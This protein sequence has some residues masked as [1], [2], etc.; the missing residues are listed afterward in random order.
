MRCLLF[1]HY[2]ECLIA[3]QC[4]DSTRSHAD[5]E[6]NFRYFSI[7][8]LSQGMV[9]QM[10]K[11]SFL[12]IFATLLISITACSNKSKEEQL[13]EGL[14]L[15][16][17]GNI[18]GAMVIYKSL[19][20]DA[21][22]YF[23]VRYELGN[24]YLESGLFEKAEKEFLKVA[25]QNPGFKEVNR[26]LSRVYVATERF[27]EA[28][29]E[30]GK[31]LEAVPTDAEAAS[32]R[33]II[34]AK[35]ENDMEAEK[36]FKA[37]LGIDPQL[38]SAKM[39]LAHVYF[40]SQWPKK[41]ETLLNEVIEQDASHAKAYHLL[42]D[43]KRQADDKK[44]VLE[45][46]ARL[47]KIVPDDLRAA[48]LS[49]LGS[50]LSG[51]IEKTN[52]MA[53]LAKK[54]HPERP[55]SALLA[56][57][58]LYFKKDYKAAYVDF[59]RATSAT[60][61]VTAMYFLGLIHFNLGEY[62]QAI[63]Q[64]QRCLD[65]APEV[66]HPRAMLAITF[67]KQKRAAEAETHAQLVLDR[68]PVNAVAYN[69]LGSALLVQGRLEEGQDALATATQLDPTL[70][71]AHLKQGL[72]ALRSSSDKVDA[73]KELSLALELAPDVL[74]TRLILA[75]QYIRKKDLPLALETLKDGLTGSTEDAVIHVYMA[76]AL[77][78]QGKVEQAVDELKTAQKMRPGLSGPYHTLAAYYLTKGEQE[79]AI[80]EYKTFLS[81][82][83]D[84]VRT[85]IA[86]GQTSLLTGKTAQATEYLKKAALL[87][88]GTEY[89]AY[90]SVLL[91]DGS[92][93]EALEL[94][95]Q[96]VQ[97]HPRPA[98]P[99]EDMGRLQLSGGNHTAA[100]E[101]F[102]KLAEL[103]PEAGLRYTTT[104]LA[105]MGDVDK[106]LSLANRVVA[107]AP[108]DHRGYLIIANIH[109][110]SGDDEKGLQ[111]LENALPRVDDTRSIWMA[112]GAISDKTNN[113]AQVRRAFEALT[114]EH[115]AYVPGLLALGSL[116]DRLGEKG[117]AE[118]LYRAALDADP[119]NVIAL[120]NLAFLY[121]DNY[122]NADRAF[123][124]AMDAYKRAPTN[125]GILETVGYVLYKQ[126]KHEE[127]KKVLE[128]TKELLTKNPTLNY[129][130]ALVYRETDQ[131][132]AARQ[133]LKEALE[134][135]EFPERARA[136]KLLKALSK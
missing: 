63:T 65:I 126:G 15:Q 53:A 44:S 92:A 3:V 42:A 132:S 81:I 32:F 58:S 77:F 87:A 47:L 22:N 82:D 41:A 10:R 78:Q 131:G 73:E 36:S 56:G 64:F 118:A 20:E 13:A 43:I 80:N 119:K 46:Y 50:F 31:R 123:A 1:A 129:H 40:K 113:T 6:M 75:M 83:P 96:I 28:L 30:I 69:V 62:E 60:P 97:K 76:N 27:E 4:S 110:I 71:D 70:A 94:L 102:R 29:A 67:L 135:G 90:L 100:L 91:K 84:D 117:K 107:K 59:Q 108:N 39:G 124:L 112:I 93:D 101:T 25:V 122:D 16:A 11:L 57:L 66:V 104:T 106:A 21:P 68:D 23:A 127:A 5:S 121:A 99:L 115:P 103:D 95:G 19:L 86:A 116:E 48:Y 35:L 98:L 130:L 136:E 51:D 88:T 54:H 134:M 8:D 26:L 85:L 33:G 133:L 105:N 89:R 24:A 45:I 9:N 125:P 38:I 61:N 120:N 14:A 52:E 18:Q 128:K 17:S 49:G 55:E 114:K 12:C 79:L 2:I 34:Y 37:A 7:F 72:Y 111:E 74:N 109:Q